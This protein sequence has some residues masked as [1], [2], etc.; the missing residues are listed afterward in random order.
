MPPATVKR[1]FPDASDTSDEKVFSL[2]QGS[3]EACQDEMK[4]LRKRLRP[5]KKRLVKRMEDEGLDKLACGQFVLTQDSEPD[6]KEPDVAVTMKRLEDFLTEEQMV[7][8]CQDNRR[9]S[10]RRR[11][12]CERIIVELSDGE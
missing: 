3:I 11:V 10:K 6:E 2:L 5:V 12:R 1:E 7:E 4:R 9:P 8:Y